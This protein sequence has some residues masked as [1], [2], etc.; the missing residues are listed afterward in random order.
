MVLKGKVAAWLRL[1]RVFFYPFNWVIY[2]IGV[3][4]AYVAYRQFNLSV[5][6]LG[7]I[8]L[9]LIELS[10]AFTNDY[11]DYPTDRIN[12]N[13][14]PFNG[15][16]RVL[17]EGTLGFNEVKAGIIIILCLIPVFG[18]LLIKAAKDVSPSSI[19]LLLLVGIFLGWGYTAPP[20]KFSYRGW[21]VGE[22]VSSFMGG[23][24]VIF[25]GYFIQTG[26]WTDPV[27]WLLGIPLFFATFGTAILPEIPDYR[28]DLSVS[29]RTIPVVFGPRGAVLLSIV[30]IAFAA[31]SGMMLWYSNLINGPSATLFLIVIL[32]ALILSRALLKLLQ[33][34]DYDRKIDGIL[35]LGLSYMF[36]FAL[37]PFLSFV[38]R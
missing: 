13:A 2:N 15:G 26:N 29:R 9:F 6:V 10:V 24:L 4:A 30:F 34:D 14:G 20:F 17:V 7:Y 22:I 25:Y 27:P 28:A 31:L 23:P 5:Y 33:S 37:I 1:A 8:C 12:K 3:A 18:Y 16:S 11:F 36:W 32:H 35:K 19:M 21:G 38:W